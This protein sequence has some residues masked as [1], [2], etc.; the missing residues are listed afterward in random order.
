VIHT[1]R[2]LRAAALQELSTLLVSRFMLF[3]VTVQPFFV[4]LTAMFVLR[5]GSAFD[6][7]YV[8]VGSALTGLWSLMLFNGNWLIGAERRQGTLELLV[9]APTAVMLV[10]AGKLIGT[11]LFSFVSMVVCYA[12]GAWLF[13]YTIEIRE[14]FPFVLSVFLA[15]AALWATALLI[16]P[17]G[18]LWRAVGQFLNVF[19]YPVYMLAGFLFPIAMLPTWSNPASWVLPPFW[20]AAAL[21]LTSTGAVEMGALLPIWAVA[22]VS[23]IATVLIAR[24]LF[25]LVIRRATADGSLALS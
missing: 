16:A 23:T 25:A 17:L 19:E 14:P 9:G 4:A 2:V 18:I 15:L 7:V 8:V 11:T 21:H 5:R 6:P 20:G 24:P 12:V 1:L 22:I 3:L 10:A 13:G